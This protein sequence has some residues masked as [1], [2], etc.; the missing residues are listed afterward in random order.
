MRPAGPPAP[1]LPG[2]SWLSHAHVVGTVDEQK[3]RDMADALVD[4][5]F[6]EAGYTYLN[7]DGERHLCLRWQTA[8]APL[9]CRMMWAVELHHADK[10]TQLLLDGALH[11][12]AN[13]S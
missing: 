11:A 3:I 1:L 2:H 7:I 6:L 12:H 8:D 13:P 5:G 10:C 4:R 9:P